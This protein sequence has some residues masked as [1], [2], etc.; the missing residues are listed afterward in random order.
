MSL[1]EIPGSSKGNPP[2]MF[3]VCLNT[4]FAKKGYK[5]CI[6]FIWFLFLLKLFYHFSCHHLR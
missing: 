4:A 6:P 5:P 3:D 2:K 1:G